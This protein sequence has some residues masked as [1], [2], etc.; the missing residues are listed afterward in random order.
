MGTVRDIVAYLLSEYPSRS[1]GDLSNAR[2]TKMVYLADWRSAIE[3][4]KTVSDIRWFFDNYGPF[5]WDVLNAVSE[6]EATFEV[7][8]G[9]NPFGSTKRLFKLRK[10]EIETPSLTQQDRTILDHVISH[11]EPKSWQSFI[12]LVYST[13][14]VVSSSRYSY[15]DLVQKAKEYASEDSA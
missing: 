5:V 14:P 3:R 1:A 12:K 7:E 15:L 2:V 9:A 6:D 4:G 8:D 13:Y 11:A 10:R